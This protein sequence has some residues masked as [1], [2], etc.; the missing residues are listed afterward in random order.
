MAPNASLIAAAGG[1]KA[2]TLTFEGEGIAANET[3]VINHLTIMPDGDH[4]LITTN[5]NV[6]IS[7][8]T[9]ISEWSDMNSSQ[10][11]IGVAGDSSFVTANDNRVRMY[12]GNRNLSWDKKF[13]GGNAQS[14]AYSRDGSTIVIGK[15]DNTME[16]LNRYGT[17]LWMAD[18]AGWITSVAVSDDGNTIAAGSMDRKLYVYNHAGS[19]LGNF[20][21][22]S[23]IDSNSVAV[24]RDG[25]IIVVVDISAVFGFS[26][27]SFTQETT[28]D[29]TITEPSSE[30]TRE[31]TTSTPLMTTTRKV[32]CRI[33]TVPTHYPAPVETPETPLPPV[34]PLLALGLLLLCRS[35]K[36]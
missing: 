25:S 2:R 22:S 7:N 19:R 20:T 9:L 29:E 14:L 16:V 34:V 30:V 3:L 33:P 1:G 13:P 23:A 4:I 11:L 32:T 21:T 31:T 24:S 8:Y 35:G 36:R 5:R 17:R 18:A 10:N 6:Q 27:A 12:T 26:R 28:T 15:D